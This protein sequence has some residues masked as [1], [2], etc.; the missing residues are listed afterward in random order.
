MIPR[1][2]GGEVRQILI[3]LTTITFLPIIVSAQYDAAPNNYYPDTYNGSIFTGVVT[4]TGD[5]Q[6]TL[7][8]TKGSK[9]DTFTGLF[10]TGC[11]VP[12]KDGRRM[13]PTD[14]PKGT[15][16]TTF[17]NSRT[18]KVDGKKLKENL[19]IAIAFEVWQGQRVADDKKIIYW[20]TDS[21]H[22]QFRAYH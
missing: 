3:L 18:K 19:I 21:R 12:S 20:C 9:T 7:T 11:S 22:L 16:M 8:F 1:R 17:F 6:I 13:I 5:N 4:E 10:E 2:K 15:V 14:I